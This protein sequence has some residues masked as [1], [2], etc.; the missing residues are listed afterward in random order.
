MLQ[1]PQSAATP[2]KPGAAGPFVILMVGVNG[3]GK[4]TTAA[5]LARRQVRD[6]RRVMLCAADTFRAA[7][8]EQLQVWAERAGA[9]FAAHRPGAD[10]SAVAFDAAQATVSR[11]F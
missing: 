1:S 4:T 2:A 10:P 11:G 6:G 7:A 5:K 3:G 8:G 9:E